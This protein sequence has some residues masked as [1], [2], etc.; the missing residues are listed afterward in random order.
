MYTLTIS[1][2]SLAFE[3][4]HINPDALAVDI[5]PH[6]LGQ[7]S[8]LVNPFVR[9]SLFGFADRGALYDCRKHVGQC[10]ARNNTISKLKR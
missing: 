8:H 1:G 5:E 6:K 9:C 3:E 7:L 4:A 10:P 2:R